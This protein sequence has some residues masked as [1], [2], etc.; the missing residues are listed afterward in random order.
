MLTMF[1]N[2]I[3]WS[4]NNLGKRKNINIQENKYLKN[5]YYMSFHPEI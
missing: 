4:I 2:Y 1:Q 5:S 3:L